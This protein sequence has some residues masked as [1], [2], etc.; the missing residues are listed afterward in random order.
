MV[1]G[2]QGT[3]IEPGPPNMCSSPQS[4]LSYRG[5]ATLGPVSIQHPCSKYAG[6]LH[7]LKSSGGLCL[8]GEE[9]LQQG[10]AGQGR[11]GQGKGIRPGNSWKCNPQAAK[12]TVGR[13]LPLQMAD[14]GTTDGSPSTAG[15][16]S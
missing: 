12:S 1:G 2:A 7:G 4:S 9:Q 14:P 15:S 16:D 10:R 11:A 3:R 8:W 6:C 5:A 13:A